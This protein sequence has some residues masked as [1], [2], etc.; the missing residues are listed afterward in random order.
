MRHFEKLAEPEDFASWKAAHPA[1]TFKDLG[2]DK[3]F[4]GAQKARWALRNSLQAEQRG[5]CCYCETRIDNGN[6]HVEHFR[7]KDPDMFPMLQLVYD[8][9]HAC[10][11]KEAHGGADEYCGHKKANDFSEQ[12]IS[13][14]EPDCSTHF[15]YDLNGGI[16]GMDERGI[17]TVSMLNLYSV[18]LRKSRKSLIEEFEDTESESF[19]SEIARHLDATATPLGEFYTVIKH[20]YDSGLLRPLS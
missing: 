6:F 13:P 15:Q 8:N 5:L 2:R 12:L 9:L 1:A 4:P 16:S 19:E 10:C 3:L 18:L 7:P 17:E 20:L 14:L 11:R